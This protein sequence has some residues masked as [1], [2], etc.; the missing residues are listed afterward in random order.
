MPRLIAIATVPVILILFY[1][2][3]R[4]K[5][6]KGPLWMLLLSL[7]GG[8]V[9]VPFVIWWEQ[10]MSGLAAYYYSFQWQ[11]AFIVSFLVA[12]LCEESMKL[13]AFML[14]IW[15]RSYFMEKFDAIVYAVYI[16]LGFALVENIM[17]VIDGGTQTGLTRALTAV[18][19][20]AIFGIAMGFYLSKVKFS[21]RKRV[22]KF[23]KA[24]LV[25]V[26]LHG[27]YNY[28]IMADIPYLLFTFVLYVIL[29]YFLGF[30]KLKV[31]SNASVFR[32]I[33]KKISGH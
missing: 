13:L 12:G 33:R 7:A 19:A 6:K 31:I 21:S 14:L 22:F 20:H 29:L 18:P 4:D 24:W 2:Y 26:I 5:Y 32:P 15:R 3:Q 28:I 23:F 16:S 10:A 27:T 30:K 11:H 25:P 1:I 17:Y 8:A 9:I